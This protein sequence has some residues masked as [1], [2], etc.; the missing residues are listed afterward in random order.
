MKTV[1]ITGSTRGIGFGLADE[2]LRRGCGVVVSGRSQAS[3]SRAV[4]TLAAR[5]DPERLLSQPCD[6][7]DYAQVVALWAAAVERF[8]A[9]DI[10]V[11]NAG[12]S[13]PLTPFWELDPARINDVIQ[14]NVTGL[15]FGSKVAM[16]GMLAQGHGQIYNMEGFGSNGTVM[17]GQALYGTSKRAVQYF[18][19]ALLADAAETP[20]QVCTLRPG[21]VITDMLMGENTGTGAVR[22]R[23]L[24]IFNILGDRVDTV[25]PWLVERMLANDKTGTNIRWLRRGMVLARF[26]LAPFRKRDVVSDATY[27]SRRDAA[28]F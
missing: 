19:E 14:A 20:V 11:N 9:V 5:H 16:Q 8:G 6:V 17:A 4:E 23:N 15:L 28:D 7:G 13:T 12:L 27:Q 2:F 24:R 25:T 10:W 22:E 26:L 3:T 18:S 1:V 21:M